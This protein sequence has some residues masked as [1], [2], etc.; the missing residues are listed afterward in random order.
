MKKIIARTTVF[1]VALV[2]GT[3]IFVL[4]LYAGERSKGP[5]EDFMTTIT[6]AVSKIERNLLGG[7]EKREEKLEWFR[8]YRNNV[9]LL[10]APDSIFFGAYDDRTQQSFQSIVALEDSLGFPLPI[11]QI[12]TAWGSKASQ[13][14][15]M[16]QS[17]AIFDLGSV[18]MITWEPWLNDF[19]PQRFPFVDKERNINEGGLNAIAEGKF[20][21]Y[22]DEWAM[23]AK[24]FRQP[25]FLRFGH[26]MND[27]YR[28]PWGPQNNAPE[29]Y[30]NAWQYLINRFDSLGAK[31]AI[32]V[33][34]PHPA[35]DYEDYFPGKDYVDWM[36]I[37]ALNYGTVAPW[38][39][40]WSFDEIVGKVYDK[41]SEKDLPVM[42]TEFGSLEVGGDRSEWYYNA[43]DS[44]PVKYPLI[45]S[46]VFFHSA[47]D[48]TTTYKTLDWTI[49]DD[50]EVIEAIRAAVNNWKEIE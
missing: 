47:N 32:W 34:S 13:N 38:S 3:L 30:V 31:N 29:D 18:P 23:Q 14:F 11:I 7:E 26:E 33:W 16:L 36:G 15:P 35:Y 9:S 6:T 42:V 22:I 19:N 27:P 46:V 8:Q 4:L 21:V 45:H 49:D 39:Q 24:K 17:Q 43:L 48:N 12:Y 20:D 2:I 10:N 37:T 25:F 41:F 28:Y 40:W 50:E 5:L 1:V 44:L